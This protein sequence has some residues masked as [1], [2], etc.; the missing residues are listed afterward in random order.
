MINSF[1][2]DDCKILLLEDISDLAVRTFTNNGYTNIEKLKKALSEEEL[3]EVIENVEVLGIRSRTKLTEKVLK[4][5]KKL[6]SV[7]CFCIGTNQV[8]LLA[9]KK[10]GIPVFNAPFSNTRSVAEMVIG[11]IIILIRDISRKNIMCHNG[12]WEKS[13]ANSYEIRGKNLGIVGYGRI[14]SQVGILA[15]SLGMNV[16]YYDIENKLQLGNAKAVN[17]FDELLKISDFVTLHVPE[18]ALTKTMIGAD[19]LTKMKFGSYLINASRGTVVD[20]DAL[21]DAITSKHLAGAAIDVFPVE[22]S[23]NDEEFVSKL[24]GLHNVILTPHIGGST[25]EAQENIAL[26]VSDKLIK[27]AELGSTTSAVNFPE[28]AMTSKNGRS[29]LLSIH[30]NAPGMLEKINGLLASLKINISAQSLQT[31]QD[32]G[33]LILETDSQIDNSVM[34]AI[35]KLPGQIKVRL[36]VS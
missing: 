8:D 5:A 33:Y 10:L 9:A 3:L 16:Y 36:I 11:E 22:P 31:E 20:I 2:K 26:E 25:K 1:K 12:G 19:E 28:V 18:T 30:V 15:E 6:M 23:K 13:A 24:R 7:G 27:N 34:E 21:H 17:D 35:E 4:K 29:R 32:V 14:G